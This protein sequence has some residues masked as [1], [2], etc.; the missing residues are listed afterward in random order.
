MKGQRMEDRW[1]YFWLRGSLN[2][3]KTPGKQ[4]LKDLNGLGAEG[5]EAVSMHGDVLTGTV[6]MKRRRTDA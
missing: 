3:D 5:W 1:E 4:F 2:P 6:L